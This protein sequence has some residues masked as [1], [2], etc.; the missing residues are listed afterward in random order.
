MERKC[1]GCEWWDVV[2]ACNEAKTPT[3]YGL[4]RKGKPEYVNGGGRW[5]IVGRFDWC[6]EYKVIPKMPEKDVDWD[7]SLQKPYIERLRQQLNEMVL[8]GSNQ[9]K[10]DE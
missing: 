4:C 3:N 7:S 6:G 2:L 10:E 5:P 1:E 9:P 8:E